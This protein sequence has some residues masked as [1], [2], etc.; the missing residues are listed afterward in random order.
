MREKAGRRAPKVCCFTQ[1]MPAHTGWLNQAAPLT[2]FK[3]SASSIEITA[4]QLD[5]V[6]RSSR[7]AQRKLLRFDNSLA[8]RW[9]TNPL[10]EADDGSITSTH[11]NT[12]P[13]IQIKEN[14]R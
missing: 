10:T 1:P 14:P 12:N 5:S 13:K 8:E 6:E 11:S 9:G 7:L 3:G 2:H 4:G